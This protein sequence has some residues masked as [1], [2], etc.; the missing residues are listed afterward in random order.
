MSENQKK[1]WELLL[2]LNKGDC[3]YSDTR[4][5]IAIRQF[6]EFKEKVMNNPEYD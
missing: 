4:V 1:I 2:S 6:E 3:G 5:D